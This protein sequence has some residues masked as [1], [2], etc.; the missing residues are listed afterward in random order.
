MSKILFVT[1]SLFNPVGGPYHSVRATALAFHKQGFK[2]SIIGTKDQASQD[3]SA[4]NYINDPD[5]EITALRKFGPYNF[6]FSFNFRAYWEL[7]READL[8]S[9]Q[10]VWML[11][12]LIAGLFALLQKKPFYFAI[13]GEFND[14][15]SLRSI[16]KRLIKPLV[17]FLFNK[18]KFIQVLN[19]REVEPLVQYGVVAP[20]KV[21]PN[22]IDL[23][24]LNVNSLK[25]KV[26]LYIGR[27]HPMKG[28][29]ELIDAWTEAKLID[30][31]LI[32]A[33]DGED[34]FKEAFLKKTQL[35]DSIEY[36]G[37]VSG[38][39]KADLLERSMW[40]VLPSFMEGMPMAVL[41]AMSYGLPV[42][43]TNECNL[44]IVFSHQAGLRIKPSVESL[45]KELKIVEA[46]DSEVYHKFTTQA[47]KLVEVHFRW[48]SV[49]NQLVESFKTN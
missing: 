49:V 17:K 20:I 35:D 46:F 33:G 3:S 36:I 18:S 40:F 38:A 34:A 42:I 8:I 21:I 48:E 39:L 1:G 44:P 10:G 24:K 43:I 13:R 5:I 31:K 22:G 32:I 6:H 12:C 19:S 4:L 41:E 15:G 16:D 23:Q 37:P 14:F 26:V 27:I 9:L 28:L 11:N 47:R 25:Q 2:V 30:W 29:I 45:V 7:I